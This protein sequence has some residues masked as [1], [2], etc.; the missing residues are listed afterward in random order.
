MTNNSNA[1]AAPDP[2]QD[3]STS[4]E[5]H[6]RFV[7]EPAKPKKTKMILFLGLTALLVIALLWALSSGIRH[8]LTALAA[9]RAA[10]QTSK[11]E[12]S[13]SSI[14]GRKPLELN[15]PTS[16]SQVLAPSSLPASFTAPAIQPQQPIVGAA[17][18]IPVIETP[19]NKPV[20]TQAGQATPGKPSMML[21][22]DAKSAFTDSKSTI[23]SAA[24]TTGLVPAPQPAIETIQDQANASK[25]KGTLTKTP[26]VHA[27]NL[28]NRSYVLARPSTIPCVLETQILSN[29]PGTTTCITTEDVY[30][31]NGAVLLIKKGSKVSGAYAQGLKTGD[32]RL[33]VVW[34]RIK[35]TDGV[36]IDVDGPSADAVGA[37][38][39][40]G[41]VD[42]K[43][44][45]RIGAAFLL[46]M[47]EDAVV[48]Q[49]S[50]NGSVNGGTPQNSFPSTQASVPKM[51]EKVLDSTLN[52]PPTIIKNRGDLITIMVNRDL[53]FDHVFENK[54][55]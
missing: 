25:S 51:S 44:P 6:G 36:V 19:K 27:A 47:I 54:T 4:T 13:G 16:Q 30:S 18:P 35:T 14:S 50:S 46:S 5:D 52:I 3:S 21:E 24:P 38:G 41:F 28:G 12:E 11:Q 8:K 26:Q 39:V 22:A 53:W 55:R 32:V 15:A 20:A 34:E 10:K 42:N 33:A 48:L 31:D 45:E 2:V 40:P 43:W 7:N 37:A 17:Q 29:L 1:S 23:L 9:E 49:A